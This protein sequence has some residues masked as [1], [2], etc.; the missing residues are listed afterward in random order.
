MPNLTDNLSWIINQTKDY[1]LKNWI[2]VLTLPIL[3][4]TAF[5][6]FRSRQINN[7]IERINT[8]PFLVVNFERES[9]D[10][11]KAVLTNLNNSPAYDFKVDEWSQYLVD[12]KIVWKL[13]IKP[14]ESNYLEGNGKKDLYVSGFENGK[15]LNGGQELVVLDYL[16]SGF[17]LTITYKNCLG[18]GYFTRIKYIVDPVLQ[19]PV[20][21]IKQPPKEINLGFYFLIFFERIHSFLLIIFIHLIW[22]IKGIITLFNKKQ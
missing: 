20:L 13:S 12:L 21:H 17:S 15:V 6:A 14:K 3:T 22:K 8:L 1:N 16:H 11:F 2:D 9:T 18:K 19:K 10:K 5:E 7:Q 4:W